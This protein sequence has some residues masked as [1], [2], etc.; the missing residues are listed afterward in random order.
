MGRERTCLTSITSP[1]SVLSASVASN[2]TKSGNIKEKLLSICSMFMLEVC[3]GWVRNRLRNFAVG[4]VA[5]RPLCAALLP[6]SSLISR[7]SDTMDQPTVKFTI[8]SSGTV[9]QTQEVGPDA[10]NTYQ[11]PNMPTAEERA[12]ILGSSNTHELIEQQKYVEKLLDALTS[13]GAQANSALTQL[14]E[15]HASTAANNN[16]ADDYSSG[17]DAGDPNESTKPRRTRLRPVS[18]HRLGTLPFRF[19]TLLSIRSRN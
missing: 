10:S 3:P 6:L 8:Y 1:V 15:Q 19:S 17:E 11:V 2:A 5:S 9:V 4:S 18:T 12:V 13:A 7:Y 14:M 16:D